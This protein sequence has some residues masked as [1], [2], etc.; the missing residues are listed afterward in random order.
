MTAIMNKEYAY[1]HELNPVPRR[2]ST[3]AMHNVFCGCQAVASNDTTA[4]KAALYV[5]CHDANGPIHTCTSE[6]VIWVLMSTHE[7]NWVLDITQ[8]C[9]LVFSG[10]ILRNTTNY[11]FKLSS[12]LV[13]LHYSNELFPGQSTGTHCPGP[14]KLPI[15]GEILGYAQKMGEH[16]IVM[17]D[18]MYYLS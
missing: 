6:K 10:Q 13:T 16:K 4:R 11:V 5:A 15:L 8:L 12:S 7:P 18:I 1:T 3:S 17:P 9:V 14:A 2:I